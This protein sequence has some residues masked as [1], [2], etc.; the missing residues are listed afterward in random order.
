MN[1]PV[2]WEIIKDYEN[3]LP[4]PNIWNIELVATSTNT[5]AWFANNILILWADLNKKTTSKDYSMLN[6][7]WAETDYLEYLK[8]SSKEI[9]FLD[10]DTGILYEFE[11]KY[12]FEAQKL[13]FLQTAHICNETKAYLITLALPTSVT[14]I[15]RYVNFISSFSCK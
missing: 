2:N 15:S 6:N 7:L 3:V 4:T 1:I 9:K 13:K 11:A 12:N 8:L 14:D 10:W 5:I